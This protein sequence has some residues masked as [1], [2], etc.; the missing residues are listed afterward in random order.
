[1][2]LKR[3]LDLMGIDYQDTSGSAFAWG[4]GF[5]THERRDGRVNLTLFG[6]SQDDAARLIQSTQQPTIQ[7]NKRKG[8]RG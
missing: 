8:A 2:S 5:W 4:D 6:I 1:M 3:N 7:V